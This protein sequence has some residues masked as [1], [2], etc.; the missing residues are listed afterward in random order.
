MLDFTYQVGEIGYDEAGR[1]RPAALARLIARS[2]YESIWQLTAPE[3]RLTG[4]G[5]IAYVPGQPIA[6]E[7]LRLTLVLGVQGRSIQTLTTAGLLPAAPPRDHLGYVTFPPALHFGGSL[8]HVDATPWHD[9]LAQAAAR[10][11]VIPKKSAPP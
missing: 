5:R 3:V 4:S 10:D 1:D 9:L 6:A 7:P 8:G 11:S 2:A